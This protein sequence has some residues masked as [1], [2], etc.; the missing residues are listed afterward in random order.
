MLD[1]KKHRSQKSCLRA[2]NLNLFHVNSR[3]GFN[4]SILLWKLTEDLMLIRFDKAVWF[5]NGETTHKHTLHTS[6]ALLYC[7]HN[8]EIEDFVFQHKPVGFLALKRL[9]SAFERSS[10]RKTKE[11]K[12]SCSFILLLVWVFFV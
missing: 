2:F 12:I 4:L 3:T 10:S 11:L 6:K 5:L 1:L 7:S 8:N 9:V